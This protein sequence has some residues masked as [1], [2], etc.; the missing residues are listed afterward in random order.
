MNVRRLSLALVCGLA[1]PAGLPTPTMAQDEATPLV[2]GVYLE[3]NP[4]QGER[5]S[6]L[7]RETWAPLV[8]SRIASG[9]M[10]AWGMITHRTGGNWNRAIYHVGTDRAALLGALDEMVAEWASANP[11]AFTEFWG[12]CPT[13]EDYIWSY[14]TG[15]TAPE[16]V[17]VMR[18]TAGMSTYWVC[19]EGRGELA[20]MIVEQVLGPLHTEQVEAGLLN[21]WSWFAH[22]VGGEYRRLLVMDGADHE[23]LL[24]ARDNVLEAIS[25]E[26]AAMGAE[27]NGVCNGHTD[28]LWN[29]E[30]TSP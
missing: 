24:V 23:S 4:A 14:V 5:A 3:C 1:L 9:E 10:T 6:E 2:Y 30:I 20:D 16:E 11:E 19:D 13:H 27:F 28:Y 18:P 17:A 29:I 21:S 26:H 22:F 25:S 12:I 7:V 8:E 15:S